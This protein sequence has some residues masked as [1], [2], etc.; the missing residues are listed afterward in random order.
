MTYGTRGHTGIRGGI[1]APVGSTK[2]SKI[3]AASDTRRPPAPEPS[4]GSL[5]LFCGKAQNR[6]ESPFCRTKVTQDSQNGTPQSAHAV[7][8]HMFRASL[9]MEEGIEPARAKVISPRRKPCLCSLRGSK[10]KAGPS[11]A[12]PPTRNGCGWRKGGRSSRDDKFKCST[13]GA[14]LGMRAQPE[15][16]HNRSPRRKPGVSGVRY[17]ESL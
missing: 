6:A 3:A 8:T 11:T 14:P 10:Q 1:G 9:C 17:S 15:G 13:I 2:I 5:S 16:R 4:S 12:R 7:G